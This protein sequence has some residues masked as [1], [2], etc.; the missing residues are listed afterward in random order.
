VQK[1]VFCGTPKKRKEKM[2]GGGKKKRENNVRQYKKMF[3]MPTIF[4]PQN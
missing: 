4:G 3:P 2:L 1:I